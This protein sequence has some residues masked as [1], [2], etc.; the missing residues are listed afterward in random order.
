[1]K[2][3][4]TTLVLIVCV[5]LVVSSA[6]ANWVYPQGISYSS[7]QEG[8]GYKT[9]PSPSFNPGWVRW[10]QDNDWVLVISGLGAFV[11]AIYLY[12]LRDKITY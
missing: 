5:G 3:L 12:E 7:G 8:V 2:T 4:W 1:V 6:T 11:S 9:L 10:F